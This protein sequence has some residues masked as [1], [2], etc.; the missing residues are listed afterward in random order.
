VVTTERPTFLAEPPA[1][2]DA[3]RLYDAQ[4]D[5]DGYVW[6]LTRLWCWRTD[7][8][9][10]FVKL[11]AELMD[12]SS[13]TDRDW[14]VLVTATASALGDSYCSLA[15]GPKLAKLSDADTAADVIRGV[16]RPDGLGEREAAL[17]AWARRLVHDPNGTTAADVDALRAVGLDDREIFEATAFVGLRL[18]FSTI[19]AALGAGPDQQLAAAAPE[20][21]R[22]AVGYGRPAG[23]EPSV[24]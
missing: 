15:W 16:A 7:T 18:A 19:N 14:A 12:G 20:S 22:A 9:D 17:A 11:R 13:L 21:V 1:T 8:F 5:S 4:R 23:A 2:G 3:A 6:N 10:A 24:A